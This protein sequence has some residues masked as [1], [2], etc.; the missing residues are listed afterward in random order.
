MEDNRQFNNDGTPVESEHGSVPQELAPPSTPTP[1]LRVRWVKLAVILLA[2]GL[3]MNVVG[4]ISGAR[5]VGLAFTQGRLRIVSFTGE[6]EVHTGA[7]GI[8][9]LNAITEININARSAR[10]IIEPA[11]HGELLSIS[12]TNISPDTVSHS[13]TAMRINATDEQTVITI[14][15]FGFANVR[16]EIRLRVPPE[17]ADS[18]SIVTTSGRIDVEGVNIENLYTRA[19]SGSVN[20]NNINAAQLSAHATSG[21]VRGENIHFSTGD[22]QS[23]SGAINITN[24]S[25]DNLT[26]RATSGAVRINDG[27]INQNYANGQ[28]CLQ[29]NSGA[30]RLA[31]RN[32]RHDFSYDLNVNSGSIRINGDRISGR[33]ANAASE[34]G[35]HAITM[36]ATSGSVRLD[37]HN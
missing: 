36:R 7:M 26:A 17:Q 27:Q 9:N 15:N 8:P 20:L 11:A 25:W 3:C 30:V 35:G 13:D 6:H 18:I 5:G 33:T 23:T 29:A 12:L 4:W 22:L 19:N 28:T 34:Q 16:R 24:A 2:V 37:F 14:M 21:A 10:V 32:S 1:K 31:L